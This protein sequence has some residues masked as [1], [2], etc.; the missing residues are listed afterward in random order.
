MSFMVNL[1][2]NFFTMEIMKKSQCSRRDDW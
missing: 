2:P 1:F